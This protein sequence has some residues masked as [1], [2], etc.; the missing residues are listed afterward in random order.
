M[1]LKILQ[2]ESK[3]FWKGLYT[4]TLFLGLI[5]MFLEIFI[6]RK[7]FIDLGIIISLILFVGMIVFVFS[8]QHYK[9][10]YNLKGNFFPLMQSIFSWGFIACY[11][12]LALNFYFADKKIIEWVLPIKSKSSI[13]GYRPMSL[14]QPTIKFNYG[15][16]E[17]ELVFYYSETAVV[18]TSQK[19]KLQIRVGAFGYDIID[20]YELK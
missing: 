4:L 14:R 15:K 3:D 13:P 1:K 10:T 9:K 17:K 5:L 19:I 7:T 18:D 6:Y 12:F 16:F 8:K 2:I 11:L 20:H